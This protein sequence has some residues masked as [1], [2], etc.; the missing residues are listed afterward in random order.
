MRD[1]SVVLKQDS[2]PLLRAQRTHFVTDQQRWR[3]LVRVAPVLRVNLARQEVEA[4]R[5]ESVWATRRRATTRLARTIAGKSRWRIDVARGRPVKHLMTRAQADVARSLTLCKHLLVFHD[6]TEV[7]PA[8]RKE[9]EAQEV[10]REDGSEKGKA[11]ED[12]IIGEDHEEDEVDSQM[13]L[14]SMFDQPIGE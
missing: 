9:E 5:L 1:P 8:E 14:F 13:D 7:L 4:A 10:E 3:R 2:V 11:E 6:H 12:M